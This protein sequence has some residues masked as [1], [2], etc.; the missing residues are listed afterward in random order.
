MKNYSK[1]YQYMAKRYPDVNL[2][3]NSPIIHILRLQEAGAIELT[4]D[5]YNILLETQN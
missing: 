2:D 5:L 4:D 3:L 1:L